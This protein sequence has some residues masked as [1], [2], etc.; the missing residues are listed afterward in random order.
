M[1]MRKPTDAGAYI[2]HH[3]FRDHRNLTMDVRK[4]EGLKTSSASWN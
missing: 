2:K 1:D 4:E 3:F